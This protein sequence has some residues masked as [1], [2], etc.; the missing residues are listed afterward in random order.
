MLGTNQSNSISLITSPF[1]QINSTQLNQMEFILLNFLS[2]FLLLAILI[3]LQF[4]RFLLLLTD[5]VVSFHHH[6]RH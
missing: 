5:E 4:F 3:F 1:K 2:I 6:L